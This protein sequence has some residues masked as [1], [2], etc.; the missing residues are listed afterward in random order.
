MEMPRKQGEKS[1]WF[2]AAEDTAELERALKAWLR[3]VVSNQ[4]RR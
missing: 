2:P 1:C 3:S 4:P